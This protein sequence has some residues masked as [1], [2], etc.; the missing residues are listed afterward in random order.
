MEVTNNVVLTKNLILNWTY[1]M[2]FPLKVRSTAFQLCDI[3]QP[4]FTANQ[5]FS[6]CFE[7]ACFIAKSCIFLA[8]KFEDIHGHLNKI[9]EQIEIKSSFTQM[10]K[11]LENEIKMIEFLDFNFSYPDL[12]QAAVAVHLLLSTQSVNENDNKSV[13][14]AVI[15]WEI[16]VENLNRA[17]MKFDIPKKTLELV[18]SAFPRDLKIDLNYEIDISNMIREKSLDVIYL[19]DNEIKELTN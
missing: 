8:C 4:F 10:P 5:E 7:Q 19:G 12:Y 1:K 9:M 18:M 3:L 2:K 17:L 16:T 15:P 13:R 11:I 14:R 6:N